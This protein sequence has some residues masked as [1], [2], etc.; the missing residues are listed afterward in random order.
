MKYL[1]DDDDHALI[2]RKGYDR[3]R[4]EAEHMLGR[5]LRGE[6]LFV[7]E[8]AGLSGLLRS[9]PLCKSMDSGSVWFE[10]QEVLK[11]EIK[12]GKKTNR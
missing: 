9:R 8:G 3:G 4:A 1:C 2:E 6:T 7:S 5:A 10:L 11:K 12:S